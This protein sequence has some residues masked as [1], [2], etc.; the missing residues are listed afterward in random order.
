M[1]TMV[2]KLVTGGI[3]IDVGVAEAIFDK[4]L[5][6]EFITVDDGISASPV[7]IAELDAGLTTVDDGI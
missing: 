4:E 3:P 6:A 7:L 5:D 2:V 1:I